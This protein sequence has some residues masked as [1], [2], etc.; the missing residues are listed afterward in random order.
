MIDKSENIC[1]GLFVLANI[2]RGDSCPRQGADPR[3]GTA[4]LRCCTMDGTECVTPQ[5]CRFDIPYR[6]ALELCSIIG[7]RLCRP[8]EL[9]SGKCCAAEK[10][11]SFDE[12]LVWQGKFNELP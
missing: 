8:S 3:L 1:Y 10:G 5:I 4:A 7:M 9:A 6:T 2:S 11:C 12:E